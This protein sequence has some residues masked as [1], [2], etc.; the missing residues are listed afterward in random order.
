MAELVTN[1]GYAFLDGADLKRFI[2]W[3]AEEWDEFVAGW[4][5][6]PEDRYLQGDYPFRRRRYSQIGYVPAR[7]H[8]WRR[9]QAPYYQAEELNQYAGGIQREFEP[10]PD[11]VLHSRIFQALLANAF[12]AMRLAPEYLDAEWFGELHMFRLQV[13]GARVTEPTPEGVHRDGFPYGGINL[14]HRQGVEGGVSHIYDMDKN[15]LD[16]G[17]LSEP[18]D[19]YYGW[20]NRIM[21]YATPIFATGRDVGTRDVLVYGLHLPDSPYARG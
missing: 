19:S 16:L 7:R 6:L 8:V 1:Q 2:D 14:V 15:L 4:G 3:T 5:D 13:E 10:V 18:L 21:H 17:V 20:D 12:A 11:T 9:E